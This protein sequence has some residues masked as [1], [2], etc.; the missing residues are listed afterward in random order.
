MQTMCAHISASAYPGYVL[1]PCRA[2][3]GTC[4][5]HDSA[6]ARCSVVTGAYC[7]LHHNTHVQ[8][9]PLSVITSI[10]FQAFSLYIRLGSLKER[11]GY[12]THSPW[13]AKARLLKITLIL[14]PVCLM[15]NHL[16]IRLSPWSR[17][18]CDIMSK[19]QVLTTWVNCLWLPSLGAGLWKNR[20][21]GFNARHNTASV[22]RSNL[23][24]ARPKP[25]RQSVSRLKA[26]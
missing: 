8:N 21:S 16:P 19:Y 7:L 11:T 5:I 3:F 24:S 12:I 22:I 23:P 13:S 4:M 2:T 17:C 18:V 6:W 14:P 1:G 20:I 25:A 26:C 10:C 15:L 9:T